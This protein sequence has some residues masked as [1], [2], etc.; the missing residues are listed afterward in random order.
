[1][2]KAKG[3]VAVA[4]AKPLCLEQVLSSRNVQTVE[5]KEIAQAWGNVA[6]VIVHEPRLS[7]A[8]GVQREKLKLA[9]PE[10]FNGTF[11]VPSR[12]IFGWK[13]TKSIHYLETKQFLDEALIETVDSL[14]HVPLGQ[15][16]A[17]PPTL[18][19]EHQGKCPCG[20]RSF[21]SASVANAS[22]QRQM[23]ESRKRRPVYKVK[24]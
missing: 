19:W 7:R 14:R 23:S 11:P 20:R 12:R 10:M 16:V 17:E 24:A 1:M 9:A 8:K 6:G 18:M 3:I 15:L 5:L 22:R 4:Y 2:V 13:D 21:L